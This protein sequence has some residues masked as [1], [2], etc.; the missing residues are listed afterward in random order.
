[1]KIYN[2]ANFNAYIGATGSEIC[3]LFAFSDIKK[4]S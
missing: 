2:S 3:S 4:S 1:M